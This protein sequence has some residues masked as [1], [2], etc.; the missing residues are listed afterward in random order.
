MIACDNEDTKMV[1]VLLEN[2]ASTSYKN[3][4]SYKVYW[5]L[6][7]CYCVHVYTCRMMWL[8]FTLPVAKITLNLSSDWLILIV[9]W[10]SRLSI[11]CKWLTRYEM[12]YYFQILAICLHTY[13][14]THTHTHTCLHTHSHVHTHTHFCRKDKQ[15]S[16]MPVVLILEG[17]LWS[18]YCKTKHY[19]TCWTRGPM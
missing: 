19:V 18:G 15:F 17:K 16:I 1:D 5:L 11:C 9:G 4:V 10:Q 13:T 12:Q 3:K 6:N 2:G 7:S 14:H 8:L